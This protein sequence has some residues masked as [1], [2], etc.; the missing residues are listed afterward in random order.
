VDERKKQDPESHE[1]TIR[2]KRHMA[3]K[4]VRQGAAE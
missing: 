4:M 1:E 2:G 3:R